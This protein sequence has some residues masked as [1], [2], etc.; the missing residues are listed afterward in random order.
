M[1][2]CGPTDK[3]LRRICRSQYEHPSSAIGYWPEMCIGHVYIVL[4]LVGSARLTFDD[5]CIMSC[6]F[7]MTKV[8][9]ESRMRSWT[10][11]RVLKWSR[12]K[13][14]YIWRLYSD[15]GKVPS[16]SGIFFGVP[17]S[18][19]NSYWALMGHTG[20]ERK[21]SRVAAPLPHGLVRIVLRKGGAPILPSHSPFPF[22]YSMW[23]VESY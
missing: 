8:C 6:V 3:D 1:L 15:I 2:L 11:Q 5:V 12:H 9:S 19:R 13:D 20:K 14:W 17:E 16:D 7:L 18:Y 22:S 23:E 4:E 21:A 10:W